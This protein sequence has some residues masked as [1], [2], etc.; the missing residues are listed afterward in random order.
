[1]RQVKMI[2]SG[3]FEPNTI[4]INSLLINLSTFKEHTIKYAGF[5]IESLHIVGEIA[6]KKEEKIIKKTC[7]RNG[8]EIW[9]TDTYAPRRRLKVTKIHSDFDNVISKILSYNSKAVWTIWELILSKNKNIFKFKIVGSGI[10]RRMLLTEMNGVKH[11]LCNME[12]LMLKLASLFNS[13]CYFAKGKVSLPTVC[14]INKIGDP[15]KEVGYKKEY[16]HSL[17]APCKLTIWSK[18]RR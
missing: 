3:T 13:T 5:K 11:H 15:S 8:N 9:L 10:N 17:I 14:D 1:M 6:P 16:E 18:C 2:K 12:D 4:E 7:L